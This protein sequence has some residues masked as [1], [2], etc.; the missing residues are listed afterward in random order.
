MSR[1]RIAFVAAGVAAILLVGF[2]VGRISAPQAGSRSAPLI[3]KEVRLLG[4]LHLVEHR[5]QTVISVESHREAPPWTQ[6]VPIVSQAVGGLV[7]SATKNNALVTV[8]GSVEA[9]VDLSKAEISGNGSE[10][11]VK[12]PRARI[13]PANVDAELHSQTHSIGWDDRNLALKARRV[14]AERFE[15]ASLKAGILAAAE[16]RAKDQVAKMFRSSGVESVRIEFVDL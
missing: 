6:G 7:E 9:G 15:A 11:A 3:L 5:Y 10:I 4:D 1:Q 8:Q 16:D 2:G 13:Y 12:L 14:G